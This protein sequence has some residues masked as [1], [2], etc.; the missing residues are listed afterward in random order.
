MKYGEWVELVLKNGKKF[1][2]ILIPSPEKNVIIIKLQNGYNI[3]FKEEDISEIRYLG[4]KI[5]VAKFPK[6][7]L[8]EKGDNRRKISIVITG[9]TIMSRVDYRTGGVHTFLDPLELL[10]QI[11]ELENITFI[12]NIVNPFSIASEDMTPKEWMKI[13]EI[14]AKELN[15]EV[16]GVIITHGTDTMHYTSA[17]LS[18]M[19]RNLG[20][21]VALVGSQRSSDRGSSDA[22]MNMICASIYA[23]SDIAEVSIVMHGTIED[24]FCLAHRGT[25]V[26][27]MHT[28]RRDAFRSINDKPLA[29][30]YPNG[31]IEIINENY[32]KRKNSEVIADTKINEKVALIKVFPGADPGI[33]DFFV[34][35][36]YKGIVIEG[37]GFGH[38]PTETIHKEKSW[39]PAIER[40]VE[41]DVIICMTSQTIFGRT[42]PFVYSN[43]RK[44]YN[45]KIIYLEDMLPEVAYVK[46]MWVLGHTENYEEVKKLMLTPLANE[47]KL[48]SLEE[49]FI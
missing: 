35:K 25:R 48:R 40:A 23:T 11:P 17:A 46:L 47:I 44:L 45:L 8:S 27:K 22:F 31:K 5:D 12:K 39:I 1:E 19:L 42:N 20:K 49:E 9:G 16:D 37:T 34:D 18:F 26:R 3:G 32:K 14:V 41:N 10:Y 21:P 13:A 29:K 4:K 2:G 30:I 28:E 6:K 7:K 36:G 33:I 15:S 38:V 43:A 24:T